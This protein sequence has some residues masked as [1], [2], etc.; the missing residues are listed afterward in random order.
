M[1]PAGHGRI[2][3]ARTPERTGVYSYEREVEPFSDDGDRAV[4]GRQGGLDRL[5]EPPAVVSAHGDRL[6]HE[7]QAAG[8]P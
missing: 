3:A 7:R 4:P 1:R 5:A 8:D 2:R 6:G